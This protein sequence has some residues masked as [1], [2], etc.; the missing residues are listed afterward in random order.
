MATMKFYNVNTPPTAESPEGQY[1]VKRTDN[2]DKFD[3]FIVSNGV[4]KKQENNDEKIVQIGDDIEELDGRKLDSETFYNPQTIIEIPIEGEVVSTFPARTIY[5]YRN[6]VGQTYINRHEGKT[7]DFTQIKTTLYSGR[8]AI[9]RIYKLGVEHYNESNGSLSAL[10]KNFSQL[11]LIH[12]CEYENTTSEWK[13]IL[14]NTKISINHKESIA[15]VVFSEGIPQVQLTL[16]S[17]T[18]FNAYPIIY[19]TID[20]NNP[21]NR[22]NIGLPPNYA[23][24]PPI[25]ILDYPY[26]TKNNITDIVEEVVADKIG[27]LARPDYSLTLPTDIYCVVGVETNLWKDA[28]IK[29]L[30]RGLASPLNAYVEFYSTKGMITE[31]CWRYT[32]QN[33]DIGTTTLRVDVRDIYFNLVETKTVNIVTIATSGLTSQKRVVDFGDSLNGSSAITRP[34]RDN[35]VN[36]GGTTPLFLGTRSTPPNNTESAGG[37][38]FSDYATIGRNAYRVQVNGIGSLGIG[39]RYTNNG[40]TWEVAE[41]N[42]TDGVGNILLVWPNAILIVPAGVLVKVTG[43]GDDIINYTGAEKV[44]GNPLWNPTTDKLDIA[45]YRTQ[46]LGLASNELLDAVT[47]R[48]GINDASVSSEVLKKYIADLYTAFITDNPSCKL[49]LHFPTTECNTANGAGV[50]YGASHLISVFVNNVF[51]FRKTLLEFDKN[52]N[53]PNI[54]VSS[55][56]LWIDR[57][58]G[59]T[60]GQRPISARFTTQESYHN[61]AQH[62]AGS[63]SNQLGDGSFA[64]LLYALM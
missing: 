38:G 52:P 26:V 64:S 49:I 20:G 3:V 35:F 16:N 36:I 25:L 13:E 59:Y 51:N 62:P 47:F 22:A 42:V 29:S 54:L 37:Y 18:T 5:A 11:N 2:T 33:T 19:S 40:Y 1:F 28:V 45:Y 23:C 12:E 9:L 4:V 39:A 24:I 50:N 60:M 61:N 14:L 27:D 55:S 57:Y 10:A 63:G 48:F 17:F 53:Y 7:V 43:T 58:Y 56:G 44:P 31:R 8:N 15:V 46:K 34:T 41:V 6:T 30:D 32:P 21:E